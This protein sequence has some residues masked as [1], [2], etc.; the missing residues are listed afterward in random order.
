MNRF[1]RSALLLACLAFAAGGTARAQPPFGGTVFDISTTILTSADP[2]T[3][4]STTYAGTGVRF[5]FDRRTN[6]FGNF[7]VHLF[8]TVFDDGLTT[9][10]DVN[11]DDFATQ[12]AAQVQALKYSTEIGRLPTVLRTDVQQ[13]WIHKGNHDFGGGNNSILIHTDRTPEYEQFGTGVLEEV[14]IHEASHTSLDADHANAPGW[15]TA[16]LND[17]EFIS[18][19]ARDNPTREDIAES[20]I[21]WMAVRHQDDRITPQIKT[22]IETSIPNRLAYFDNQD[23][24]MY[25][26]VPVPEPGMPLLIGLAV[27]VTVLLRRVRRAALG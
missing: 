27:G 2:T 11:I 26:I 8:N 18:T 22:L 25:P 7:T 21:A 9:E 14:L 24:D 1:I 15:L 19:Y 4:V 20:W 13:V 12:A 16:Q 5:M 17:P 23:F 6:S 10:I 3:H